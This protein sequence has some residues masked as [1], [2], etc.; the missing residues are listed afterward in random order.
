MGPVLDAEGV[1]VEPVPV[2]QGLRL[3]QGSTPLNPPMLT[4]L[5]T[6]GWNDYVGKPVHVEQDV[7]EHALGNNLLWGAVSWLHAL[8]PPP[9]EPPAKKKK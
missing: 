7:R 8:E 3:L 5:L 6:V 4:E 2:P 1:E 9:P